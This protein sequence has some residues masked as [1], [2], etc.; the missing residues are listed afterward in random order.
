MRARKRPLPKQTIRER[1]QEWRAGLHAQDD[2]T[3]GLEVTALGLDVLHSRIHVA[4]AA[5]Q[6][7]AFVDRRSATDLIGYL[8]RR[9]GGLGNLRT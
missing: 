1:S 5:L 4:K 2:P 9:L 6:R 8:H 7:A 3:A